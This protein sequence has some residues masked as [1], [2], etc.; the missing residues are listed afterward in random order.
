MLA[1]AIYHGLRGTGITAIA[2]RA[3][4]GGVIL[5]YHNIVAT[6]AGGGVGE[7]GLHLDVE[8]FRAQCAWLAAHYAVIPLPEFAARVRGGR[9]LRGVAAITCDDAYRGAVDLAWPILRAMRLPATLFVPT[10][11]SAADGFWWDDPEVVDRTT[12]AQRQQWLSE[13]G[14]DA[15]RIR[16]AVPP[17]NGGPPETHRRADWARL[18]EV[19]REGCELGVHSSSHRNLVGLADRELEREIRGSREELAA[20]TGV[21]A[22]SFSYPYGL[23]DDRV[24][25][26]VR[27]AGYEVAVTLHFGLNGRGADP[28]ALQRINV[29]ASIGAAAFQSWVAGLRPRVGETI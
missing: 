12:P 10:D 3:R 2:R 8:R 25:G 14:G 17:R 20:H 7:P 16:G 6:P 11:V 29:P 4:R 19:A 18:R 23:S 28:F 1:T 21:S 13:L 15:V 26:A 27:D 5:C 24:R 9:S 22:R